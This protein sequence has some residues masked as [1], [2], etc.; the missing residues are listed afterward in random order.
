MPALSISK[1]QS[2]FLK[3][4]KLE[5][6]GS[7]RSD[8]KIDL[9][10]IEQALVDLAIT[11][12]TTAEGELDLRDAIDTGKLADSIQFN[13][14]KFMGGTYS[15]DINVLDYY[16]FVNSGVKGVQSGGINSPFSFKD[17]GVSKDFAL[18]IRKW[19]IRHGLKARTKPARSHPLG[20][21]KKA[22]N[23]NT[24]N[25]STNA[26]AYAIA[27]NI[28]K[29]GLKPTGFWDKAESETQKQMET[30][31]GKYFSIAIIN[32]IASK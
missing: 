16:K 32:A 23:L 1:S 3:T 14:V 8:A 19:I 7:D 29:R 27:T 4:V 20:T 11:F 26:L 5:D 13:Q 22:F 21:E 15:I 17:L 30:V 2:N 12:K 24:L 6:I 25:K 9:N 18:S 31:L 10:E 28:K